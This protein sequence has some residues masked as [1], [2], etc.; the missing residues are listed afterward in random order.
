[1]EVI[2]P[3]EE[4]NASESRE[5]VSFSDQKQCHMNQSVSTNRSDAT[6]YSATMSEFRY[7]LQSRSFIFIL[8]FATIHFFK[9][10]LYLGINDEILQSYGDG[11]HR[12]FYTKAFGYLVPMGAF[13]IPFVSL[14]AARKGLLGSLRVT[15]WLAVVYSG[16][17][18]VP[19]LEV[20]P[21]AMLFYTAYR[22]FLFSVVSAFNARVFGY[23]AMGTIQGI[24]S[25]SA[26]L[27]NLTQNLLLDF[28]V[29]RLH[30]DFTFLGLMNLVLCL[31]FVWAIRPGLVRMGEG[32]PG[33][34]A[35]D[36]EDTEV[37]TPLLQRAVDSTR[38]IRAVHP[39]FY[40]GKR[41]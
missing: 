8:W 5:R 36:D 23:G 1:M 26:S 31:P 2:T 40:M 41:T 25:F 18:L 12:F 6:V 20:Q 35:R 15:N 39:L 32:N 21:L 28:T 33:Y 4:D 19:A 16:I 3:R 10:A 30:G 7:L 11:L 29:K 13:C 37:E 27:L 34:D 38:S 17:M 22:A 14:V 24:V 9:S